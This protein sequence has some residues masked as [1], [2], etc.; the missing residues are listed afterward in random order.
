MSR[1]DIILRLV[2]VTRVY[3]TKEERKIVALNK[4]TTSFKRGEF[5]AVVGKSGSGKS[6]LIN[7][8]GGLDT[9]TSGDYF[10]EGNNIARINEGQWDAIRNEKIG[11]IFQEYHLIEY[12]SV[13]KNVEIALKYQH[14]TSRKSRVAK[15]HDVLTR[16]GLADHMHKLPGQL[17]GGQRQRVAIARALVKDPAIILADEPTG[18]LDHKT[19]ENVIELIKGLSKERLVI[20]V[21]HDRGIANEHATRIIELAEGRFTSDLIREDIE[22]TYQNVYRKTKPT[23]LNI[24]D[25][26]ELTFSKIRSQLLRTFFTALSLA[27]AFSFTILFSG[28]E[29][30]ISDSYDAYFEALNKANSY[31]FSLVPKDQVVSVNNYNT[32][33]SDL[34]SAYNAEFADVDSELIQGYSPDVAFSESTDG[35]EQVFPNMSRPDLFSQYKVR[36]IDIAKVNDYSYNDLFIGD[37]IYPYNFDEMMVTTKF[38][39]EYFDLS[40]DVVNLSS[41]VDTTITVPQYSFEIDEGIY[42]VS[43]YLETLVEVADGSIIEDNPL[44]TMERV[45]VRYLNMNLPHYCYYYDDLEPYYQDQCI[46]IIRDQQYSRYFDTIEDYIA[47][48]DDFKEQVD[49]IVPGY[50]DMLLRSDAIY[51]MAD[52]K[53]AFLDPGEPRYI[54]RVYQEVY[55]EASG[56]NGI[57][58]IDNAVF[59]DQLTMKEMTITGIIENDNESIVYMDFLTYNKLFTPGDGVENVDGYFSVNLESGIDRDNDPYNVAVTTF[60]IPLTEFHN[61]AGYGDSYEIIRKEEIEQGDE[62]A[63]YAIDNILNEGTDFDDV[64]VAGDVFTITDYSGCKV[65]SESYHYLN[66]ISILFGV[67]FNTLMFISIIFFNI[68]LSVILSERIGEIG[69]YRSVGSTA[70]DIKNLFFIE[71]VFEILLAAAMSVVMIYYAN[72]IINTVFLLVINQGS[73][74]INFAGMKLS[75]GDDGT[76]TSISFFN[77]LFYIVVV[78]VLLGFLSNRNVTKLANTKPI[79]ILRKDGDE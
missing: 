28:I 16:V 63:I 76:I 49:S 50:F 40:D 22:Q 36:L 3:E 14:E 4:V 2:D 12:L 34:I 79:D 25:K 47:Y 30:G 42:N 66:S 10:L 33:L 13:Y 60:A 7:I 70:K 11:F 65:N 52:E 56:N 68:L 1:G 17:S 8:L 71:I 77:L 74:V 18:A 48:M 5:V 53:D 73:G 45:E 20:V 51:Y 61:T 15:I 54:E 37:S 72:E 21:T 23:N 9:P 38:Y 46:Q 35:I 41:Y 31:A 69:I 39:R 24:W 59:R 64:I 55:D 27:L 67:F 78:F 19:S 43:D 58:F 26:F 57:A 62:C 6:T 29:Q 75:V 44:Y 32:A